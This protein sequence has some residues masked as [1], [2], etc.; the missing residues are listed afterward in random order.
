MAMVVSGAIPYF[1]YRLG[2]PQDILAVVGGL[3]VYLPSWLAIAYLVRRDKA[4]EL[5]SLRS[6]AALSVHALSTAVCFAVWAWFIP[7]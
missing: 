5:V 3:F 1:G 6:G 2:T 4:A 7:Y